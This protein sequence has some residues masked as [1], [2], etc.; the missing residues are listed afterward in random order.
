MADEFSAAFRRPFPE[1]IAAF[2]LRLGDLVPTQ[3]W[4]DLENRM[5]DRAFMV[6]GAMKTDLLQELGEA[7][8]RV[9]AEGVGFEEFKRDFLDIAARNG[10]SGWTG[11]GTKAGEHW[12]ARVIYRTNLATTYA[13]G[14]MAQ[15]RAKGFP[16]WIY[17]HGGSIEPRLQHLSWD[18]LVLPSDHPFW[19]THAP[20]N[21][22]GCSCYIVG[23]RSKRAALRL[24]GDP[25]KVLP[26]DW[27]SIDPRTGVPVGLDRGWDYPPGGSVSDAVSAYAQKLQELPA[28]PAVTLIQDWLDGSAFRSWFRD[29]DGFWPVARV[30]RR[31]AFLL[32]VNRP[33]VFLSPVTLSKQLRRHPEVTFEEYRQLASVISNASERIFDGDRSL[34]YVLNDPNRRGYVLVV[35][36]VRNADEI[37]VTSY[38]RLPADDSKLAS[39]LRRLRN[40]GS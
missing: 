13:A 37:F 29:P 8:D 10:W 16:Y 40:K 18:G 27:Q 30:T 25:S 4:D 20:P 12:R 31:D 5:H 2:R 9:V 32:G 21:G 19:N 35:K 23:A 36:A 38:R 15:L 28:R 24:G 22:W 34:I 33:V 39:E 7:V 6:A 11:Q 1:Q 3:R 14:R 26:D 17:F